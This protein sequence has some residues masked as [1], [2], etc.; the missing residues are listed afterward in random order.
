[1]ARAV[2]TVLRKPDELS[3]KGIDALVERARNTGRMQRVISP[4]AALAWLVIFP[5]GRIRQTYS[6]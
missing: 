2:D 4:G 6:A 5:N 3:D 1:M